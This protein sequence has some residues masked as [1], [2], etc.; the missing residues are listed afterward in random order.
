[1]R[2][3]VFYVFVLVLVL[4]LCFEVKLDFGCEIEIDGCFIFE[5]FLFFYKKMFRC[6]CVKYDVCYV[7]VSFIFKL[8]IRKFLFEIIGI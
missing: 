1:M 5:K 6:V 8:V 7:C 2:L 3:L 4:F